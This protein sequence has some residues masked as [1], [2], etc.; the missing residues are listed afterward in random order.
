MKRQERIERLIKRLSHEK[1]AVRSTAAIALANMRAREAVSA[2]VP[3]QA[4]K[5]A[6]PPPPK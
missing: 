5:P 2:L 1:E 6:P 4:E 3:K